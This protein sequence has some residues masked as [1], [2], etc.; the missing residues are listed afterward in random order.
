M[1]G[2]AAGLV[3]ALALPGVAEIVHIE[4]SSG[5]VHRGESTTAVIAV[6]GD[7]LT[8]V[9]AAASH[10]A[11]T[12]TLEVTTACQLGDRTVDMGV[13]TSEL[14]PVGD[15]TVT[16][17]EVDALGGVVGERVWRLSVLAPV[18]PTSTSS[19]SST[20]STTSTTAASTTTTTPTTTSTSAPGATSS[21]TTTPARTAT[22][23]TST[24]SSTVTTSSVPDTV[25]PTTSGAVP[26]AESTTTT[27][28]PSAT[29]G[30]QPDGSPVTPGEVSVGEGDGLL[31]SPT[32]LLRAAL[33]SLLPPAVAEIVV[34]PLLV[35]DVI[36]RAVV[37]SGSVLLPI[38]MLGAGVGWAMWSLVPTPEQREAAAHP[39][40]SFLPA[41]ASAGGAPDRPVVPG[42]GDR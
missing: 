33:L 35:A 38:A 24:T 22:T 26:P 37:A 40:T 17:R 16:I 42:G 3:V 21:T 34:S 32:R 12:V 19:T 29:P 2:A 31:S 1:A 18:T 27:V 13:L 6:T 30:G 5:R 36:F 41:V 4:P 25:P 23:S 20:S 7:R 15:H 9:S 8:C 39:A 10:P 11:I 14:T 28:P